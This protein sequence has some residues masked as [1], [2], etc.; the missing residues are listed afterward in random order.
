MGKEAVGKF[1]LSDPKWSF[2]KPVQAVSFKSAGKSPTRQSCGCRSTVKPKI[3]EDSEY[4]NLSLPYRGIVQA[5]VRA[6]CSRSS[7]LLV[8]K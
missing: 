6:L 1:V 3:R 2:H 7:G 8:R 5:P 4:T